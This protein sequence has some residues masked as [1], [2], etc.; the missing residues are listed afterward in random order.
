MSDTSY[1]SMLG[2]LSN[3]YYQNYIEFEEYRSQRKI[4]LDKI[5]VEFNGRKSGIEIA[6]NQD[7]SSILMQ[8]ISFW[9]NS[10]L[11]KKD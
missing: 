6:E 4:L 3:D 2:K 9:K 5:D 11:D 1:S 8:T 10:D 7:E